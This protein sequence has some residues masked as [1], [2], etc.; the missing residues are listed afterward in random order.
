MHQMVGN[1][2]YRGVQ[3]SEIANLDYNNMKSYNEWHEKMIE[4]EKEAYKKVNKK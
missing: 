4:A 1:L 3:P 2:F